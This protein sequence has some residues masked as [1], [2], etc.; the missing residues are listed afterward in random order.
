LKRQFFWSWRCIISEMRGEGGQPDS[1]FYV[2]PH[3][4]GGGRGDPCV[5]A[6]PGR[7]L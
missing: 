5:E 3:T 7:S 4:M 6:M 1:L 2:L